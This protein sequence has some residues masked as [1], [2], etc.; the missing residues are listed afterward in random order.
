MV[1]RYAEAVTPTLM[2]LHPSSIVDGHTQPVS[3]A[4]EASEPPEEGQDI[5]RGGHREAGPIET[6]Q[7]GQSQSGGGDEDL[8]YSGPTHRI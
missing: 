3:G 7:Y 4:P 1:D 8:Q 2:L 5:W 6:V